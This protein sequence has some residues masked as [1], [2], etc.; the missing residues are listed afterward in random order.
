MMHD[1]LMSMD[2]GF[3]WVIMTVGS[4]LLLAV[5]IYVIAFIAMLLSRSSGTA[6]PGDSAEDRSQPDILNKHMER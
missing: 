3:G 5:L 2:H 6:H 1:T 4:L